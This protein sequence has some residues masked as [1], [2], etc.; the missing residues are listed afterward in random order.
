[1]RDDSIPA[2]GG[3]VAALVE[4]WL[5]RFELI[6]LLYVLGDILDQHL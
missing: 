4:I 1:M 3:N 6:G 5:A 2:D